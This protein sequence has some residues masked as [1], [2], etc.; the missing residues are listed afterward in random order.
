VKNRLWTQHRQKT[1]QKQLPA[2]TASCQHQ[3][4]CYTSSNLNLRRCVDASVRSTARESD[5][6]NPEFSDGRLPATCQTERR[7]TAHYRIP[8]PADRRQ[9]RGGERSRL[10]D[11][12]PVSRRRSA[13]IFLW[14]IQN[15]KNFVTRRILVNPGL[16]PGHGTNL[17]RVHNVVLNSL[18]YFE[19]KNTGKTAQELHFT[20]VNSRVLITTAA[21]FKA[22]SERG[23]HWLM[24]A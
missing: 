20:I 18:C 9:S 13:S 15:G 1:P 22:E 3:L 24:C 5:V 21:L 14:R 10:D 23:F 12:Y 8:A 4:N 6:L 19:D 7:R 17:L 11:K 2:C 16:H